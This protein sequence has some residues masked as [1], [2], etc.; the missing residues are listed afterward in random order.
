VVAVLVGRLHPIAGWNLV[1]LLVG[2]AV[3]VAGLGLHASA[4][5]RRTAVA[6]MVTAGVAAGLWVILPS[7]VALA[8]GAL[9]R[10][11][12][13]PSAPARAVYRVS[14][15]V[16][17]SD[18]VRAAAS[19][20]ASA[21]WRDGPAGAAAP[22]GGDILRHAGAVLAYSAVHV[23]AGVLLLWRAA[24]RFRRHVF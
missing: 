14:P 6:A 12:D 4:R 1:I 16:Q 9:G 21:G 3:F 8:A 10:A 17:V 24:R 13:L 20:D 15:F 7:V 22:Q 5:F 19:E 23:L 11:W 18:I 2:V